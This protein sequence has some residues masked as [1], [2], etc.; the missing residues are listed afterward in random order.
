MRGAKP[1]RKSIKLQ[2]LECNSLFDEDYRKRHEQTC[3][4]EKRVAVEWRTEQAQS[5]TESTTI[6]PTASP[7]TTVSLKLPP[8]WPSD[9]ALWFSQVGAQFTIRKITTEQT[10]YAY[11]VGSLQPEVAQE[12]RELLIYPPAQNPYIT[13][14]T[15]LV[16]RTSASEQQRL[17]QLLTTEQLGDWKPTLPSHATVTWRSS[18]GTQDHETIIPLAA[19]NERATDPCIQQRRPGHH[20][21]GKA[22]RQNPRG[23]SLQQL[24]C[25]SLHCRSRPNTD[26]VTFPWSGGTLRTRV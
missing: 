11:V 22:G 18:T 20:E 13:L 8:Y 26:D 10:K 2:C 3:H 17:H 1:K 16:K 9:P 12:V 24:C 14:K 21:F 25:K 19:A 7:I 23:D 4:Q 15:E 5:S 6:A